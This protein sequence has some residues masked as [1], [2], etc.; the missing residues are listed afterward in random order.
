MEKHLQIIEVDRNG[1]VSY[2][3]DWESPTKSKVH[4]GLFRLVFEPVETGWFRSGEE[5]YMRHG[6]H[7]SSG[8]DVAQTWVDVR[9]IC[10]FTGP[11]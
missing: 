11:L 6:L 1:V 7:T 8:T 4:Q 9:F 2:K 3:L 10:F 5:A